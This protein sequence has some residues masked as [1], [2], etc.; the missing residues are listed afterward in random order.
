MKRIQLSETELTRLIYRVINEDL[1]A[2]SVD[3]GGQCFGQEDCIQ[4]C[5]CP[6]AYNAGGDET[7]GDTERHC[8]EDYGQTPFRG[9][10]SVPTRRRFNETDDSMEIDPRDSA[11]AEQAGYAE[12]SSSYMAHNE[13][14]GNI[15]E[16]CIDN[17]FTLSGD[18]S[19]REMPVY[20]EEIEDLMFSI[21]EYCGSDR[22]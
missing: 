12:P 7:G 19:M 13:L 14:M 6:N 20:D 22:G 17:G 9:S 5:I 10:R 11:S 15:D 16:W 4:G 2:G 8:E 3:C 1:T 21:E 18:M